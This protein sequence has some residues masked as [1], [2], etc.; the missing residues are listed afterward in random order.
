MGFERLLTAEMVTAFAVFLGALFGGVVAVISE[1]RKPSRP[2]DDDSPETGP[3]DPDRVVQVIVTSVQEETDHINRTLWVIERKIGEQLH[4]LEKLALSGEPRFRQMLERDS[5]GL[6]LG[7]HD[8]LLHERG[9]HGRPER[10]WSGLDRSG[11]DRPARDRPDRDRADRDRP[12]RDRPDRDRADRE[13][14]DRDSSDRDYGDRERAD[15]DRPPRDYPA[16]AR[17]ARG[18]EE[19]DP[20]GVDSPEDRSRD[21][22]GAGRPARDRTSDDPDR[23]DHDDGP[24]DKAT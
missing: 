16:R 1:L 13:R 22:D 23:A 20:D 24:P 9:D 7:Q 17:S 2:V 3:P 8:R 14:A 15:R 18:R 11:R 6:D 19:P 5:A 12:A 21:A 10:D 4:R